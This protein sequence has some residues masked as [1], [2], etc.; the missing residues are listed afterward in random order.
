MS[1]HEILIAGFG[2]Q[3]ILFAGKVLA[4]AGMASGLNVSWMPSYG[5][6]MRG[7]TC[8]C[9]VI[10]SA[11][12]VSC[13]IVSAPTDLVAMNLPSLEK[14]EAAVAPGGRIFADSSLIGGAPSRKDVSFFPIPATQLAYDSGLPGLANIIMVG[15]IARETGALDLEILK[16]ALRKVAGK[17]KELLEANL[18]AVELGYHDGKR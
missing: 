1:A 6:E 13:P 4:E 9:G 7:G 2:G 12:P 8:N 16:G 17:K 3:G 10:V 18:R 11:E 14:F 15:K 5:P